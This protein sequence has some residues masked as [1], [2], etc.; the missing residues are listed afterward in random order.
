VSK[1]KADRAMTRD[2]LAE[3]RR[4][5]APETEPTALRLFEGDVDGDHNAM[6]HFWS[7]G[8]AELTIEP[9]QTTRQ[10]LASIRWAVDLLE[11]KLLD[12][13]GYLC[14]NLKLA[15]GAL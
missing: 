6:L 9:G 8:T 15:G 3:L 12:D 14:R 7:G 1:L 11:S 10:Q 13:G 2:D 4:I 5:V